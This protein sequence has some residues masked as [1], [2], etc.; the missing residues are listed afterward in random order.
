[1]VSGFYRMQCSQH[2]TFIPKVDK[3][4]EKKAEK[5]WRNGSKQVKW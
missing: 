2:D 4:E 5:N 3:N 1:M